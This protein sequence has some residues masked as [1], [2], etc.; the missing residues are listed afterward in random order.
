MTRNRKNAAVKAARTRA[1]NRARLD[2]YLTIDK[3]ARTRIDKLLNYL[4]KAI[5]V[6]VRLAPLQDSAMRLRG[7]VTYGRLV[8]VDGMTVT[9]LPEGYKHAR[10]YHY[11]FW[12]PLLPNIS[13][14]KLLRG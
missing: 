10:E 6:T 2:Q 4:L 7:G 12:E 9:V 14:E 1:L 11:G 5:P 8:A 13:K 3:P